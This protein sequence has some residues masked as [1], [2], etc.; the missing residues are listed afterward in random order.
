MAES[1]FS[2]LDTQD[3]PLNEIESLFSESR[4]IK[5]QFLKTKK[6]PAA[7]EGRPLI[8]ML[9]FEASTRTR[10]SFE[11][12]VQRLGGTTTFFDGASKEGTSL[13]KG[14]TFDDTFWTLH[15]MLPDMIIVRCGEELHLPKLRDQ[16]KMPLINA[17]YGTQSHPTQALLDV[18]T[19]LENFPDLK[20]K[21]V[22]FAG[23]ILH[24]R[25]AHSHMELLPRMG[26]K[27]GV[28]GP[29]ALVQGV[30]ATVETFESLY[31]AL[32]WADV[33][34]GLRVQ[35][36]RHQKENMISRDDY[37][38]GYQ[39]RKEHGRLMKKDALLMHPGP[40]N[41]GLEFDP[42]VRDLSN[43][44]MWD[45]KQNGVFVRAALLRLM[46]AKNGKAS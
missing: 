25:V 7:F 42:G 10:L 40:V 41:W 31:K 9:F 26:A 38:A 11:M 19:M 39:I 5:S 22:L 45:Q 16:V 21:N 18:F 30:P 17:G 29:K 37:I 23:D 20:G 1:V 27:I 3:L 8:A 36:E 6:F 32:P 15:S 2:F 13:I 24:S 33:V 35:F 4:K 44:K 34:V 43:F 14:E 28:V 12:A 46:A